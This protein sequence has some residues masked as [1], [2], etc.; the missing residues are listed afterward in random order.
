MTFGLDD[1][2]AAILF[3]AMKYSRVVSCLRISNTK[4]STEGFKQLALMI[5]QNRS[6][7]ELWIEDAEMLGNS[8]CSFDG[9]GVEREQV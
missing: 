4:F 2:Y 8:V 1:E 6:I 9:H 7:S 3:H 5:Q